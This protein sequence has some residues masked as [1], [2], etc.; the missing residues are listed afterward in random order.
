[1]SSAVAVVHSAMHVT[2]AALH[3][4]NLI[5]TMPAMVAA[6]MAAAVPHYYGLS[7]SLRSSGGAAMPMVAKAARAKR[8][9]RIIFSFE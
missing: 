5:G 9:L 8:T 2:R 4:N 3:D 6:V 1:M 7:I